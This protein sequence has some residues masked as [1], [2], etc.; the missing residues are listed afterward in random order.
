M[1]V[2]AFPL[3]V[4]NAKL[5]VLK[6]RLA[7][8]VEPLTIDETAALFGTTR[9]TLWR[10]QHA[11]LI[12]FKGKRGHA[13]AQRCVPP[14]ALRAAFNVPEPNA[15]PKPKKAKPTKRRRRDTS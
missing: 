15:K 12:Q 7:A 9:V 14:Q 11:G 6:A 5:D 3:P 10:W 8:L 13:P 1:S 2:S 4:I